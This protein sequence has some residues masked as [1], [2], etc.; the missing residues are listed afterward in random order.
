VSVQAITWVLEAAA[1]LRP[2]LVATLI[3]LANHAD[4]SGKGAYPSQAT[5][6]GYTRKTKRGIR[7]DLSQLE[8]DGL[9]ER[10]DQR[11]VQHIAADER[12]VVWNL[13]L[14]R[15][16]ASARSGA[17]NDGDESIGE[18]QVSDPARPT[19]GTGERKQGSGRQP[20]SGR[21][22]NVRGTGSGVPKGPEADFRLT[23]L[24]PRT[25]P[26]SSPRERAERFVAETLG[27]D[28]DD[29]RWIVDQVQRRHTPERLGGYLRRMAG[30]GD[31]AALLAERRPVTTPP[32][33]PPCGQ[34]GPGRLVEVDDGAAAARCPRCHPNR[35]ERAA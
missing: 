27:C 6:A 26:S 34:C 31:L 15:K 33:E 8:E 35:E 28:D 16:R 23:V 3:G 13:R 30:N 17:G 11:L 4:G 32:P 1:D 22:S 18:P 12:P 14:D 29:A 24:E 19:N 25:K 9:I 20:T 5:L 10:G 21:K 7:N 2:H